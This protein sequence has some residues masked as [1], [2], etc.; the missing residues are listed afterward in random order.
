MILQIALVILSIGIIGFSLGAFVLA[1]RN[2][3]LSKDNI[4]LSNQLD[5]ET[6]IHGFELDAL[7]IKIEQDDESND[8][9]LD[10]IEDINDELQDCDV[11]GTVFRRFNRLLQKNRR[12]DSIDPG[13]VEVLEIETEGTTSDSG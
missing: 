1:L 11:P 13:E 4:I 10:E 2:G 7:K 6:L 9:L 8:V 12:K 3:G 5:E